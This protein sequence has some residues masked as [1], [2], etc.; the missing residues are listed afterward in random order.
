VTPITTGRILKFG[1]TFRA[2]ELSKTRTPCRLRNG[3]QHEQREINMK[4]ETRELNEAEIELV[5]GGRMDCDT[6]C[7]LARIYL[8]AGIALRGLGNE[9]QA[10]YFIGNARGVFDGACK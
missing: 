9:G 4:Y 3:P 6:A 5:A 7:V 1:V 8:T 2:V 10:Q